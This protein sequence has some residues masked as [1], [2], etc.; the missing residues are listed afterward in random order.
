MKLS[1]TQI[2]IA[3]IIVLAFILFM[4]MSRSDTSTVPPVSEAPDATLSETE[5][6]Q[7]EIGDESMVTDDGMDD[8]SSE[9]VDTAPATSDAVPATSPTIDDVPSAPGTGG[10]VEDQATLWGA[11]VDTAE[12]MSIDEPMP[13]TTSLPVDTEEEAV[14]VLISL[15]SS[16]ELSPEQLAA[17]RPFLIEIVQALEGIVGNLQI[18]V[19]E[20]AARREQL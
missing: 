18:M 11:K 12:T 6:E 10:P 2:I 8:T 5:D 1:R 16:G 3:I 7:A 4:L 20:E 17:L 9:T 14:P 15:P 13:I 19:N